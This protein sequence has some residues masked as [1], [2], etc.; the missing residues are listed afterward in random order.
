M[1]VEMKF[2]KL[3]ASSV[4]ETVVAALVILLSFAAGMMLY[5]K[6]LHSGWSTVQMV[7]FVQQSKLADSLSQAVEK[8][9]QDIL[10]DR[11]R[12]EVRFVHDEDLEGLLHLR[13]RAYDVSGR[14]LGDLN[15]MVYER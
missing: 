15:R 8:E 6:T 10:M 3:K 7:S 11:I 2:G 13:I 14:R 12:Y 1:L 5:H 4:L 9:D